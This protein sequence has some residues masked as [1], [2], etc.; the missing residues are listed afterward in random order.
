VFLY[1][2][3]SRQ[4]LLLRFAEL[5]YLLPEIAATRNTRKIAS[6]LNMRTYTVAPAEARIIMRQ[7]RKIRR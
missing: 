4:I 1:V 5:K 7:D 2:F 6:R 3:G